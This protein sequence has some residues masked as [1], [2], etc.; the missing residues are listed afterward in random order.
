MQ[1][2]TR[3]TLFTTLLTAC[4]APTK[5]ADEVGSVFKQSQALSATYGEF[6]AQMQA[7][8]QR[9]SLHNVSVAPDACASAGLKAQNISQVTQLEFAGLDTKKIQEGGATGT[10]VTRVSART[11]VWLNK[12]IL[13]LAS[14]L[15]AALSKGP[16]PAAAPAAASSSG[17]LG[18]DGLVQVAVTSTKPMTFEKESKLF[19][20]AVNINAT[21]AAK[22]FLD[23]DIAG[24]IV[25]NN[26]AVN[27]DSV[28]EQPF[29]KSLLKGLKVAVLIVPFASDVYVELYMD[30]DVHSI[31]V[32]GLIAGQVQAALTGLF[33]KGL[34]SLLSVKQ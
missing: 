20:T 29:E 6:C 2:L 24:Q 3:L 12:S 30:L 25:G 31:G 8:Q 13:G 33:K 23:L 7:R 26:I 11:Q 15:G 19:T 10:G 27:I 18:G 17:G 34:D 21:G 9:P 5:S 1:T 32:D 4:G 14:M 16:Q 28:G 22:L